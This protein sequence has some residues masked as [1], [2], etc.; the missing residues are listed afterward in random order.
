MSALFS[1]STST[2]ECKLEFLGSQRKYIWSCWVTLFYWTCA[3][4]CGSLPLLVM[5][6]SDLKSLVL[7]KYAERKATALCD[8]TICGSASPPVQQHY[9]S[10]NYCLHHNSAGW[11]ITNSGARQKICWTLSHSQ[12]LQ[13]AS[14]RRPTRL[15]GTVCVILFLQS[16]FKAAFL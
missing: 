4:L 1:V 2:S 11:Q 7:L 9:A 6:S 15:K 10:L 16:K 13:A 14:M 12:F 3:S 5:L 8:T